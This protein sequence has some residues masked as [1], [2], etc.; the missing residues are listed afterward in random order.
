MS[1]ANVYAELEQCTCP[2]PTTTPVRLIN[3][4]HKTYGKATIFGYVNGAPATYAAT[5]GQW[6]IGAICIDTSNG[7]VYSNQGSIT[8][9]PSWV[10]LS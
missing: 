10:V 6:N 1:I 8:T 5:A 7:I 4:W 9:T 2:A 3:V